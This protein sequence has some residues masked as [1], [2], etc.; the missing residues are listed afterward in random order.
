[1]TPTCN[2]G[3]LGIKSFDLTNTDWTPIVAPWSFTYFSFGS[4]FDQLLVKANLADSDTMLIQQG[5]QEIIT[6]TYNQGNYR[7][8]QGDV[9]FFA[10]A[11]TLSSTTA[12]LVTVRR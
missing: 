5:Y 10:Q 8:T 11:K 12:M 6:A 2:N 1:M 4:N 9:L 3:V 7:Y